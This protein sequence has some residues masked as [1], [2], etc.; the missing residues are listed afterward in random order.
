[1]SISARRWLTWG[2]PG[3][4]L[5]VALGLFLGWWLWP[6]GYAP[7][8][9]AY[10]RSDHRDEYVLMIAQAYQVD[11]DLAGARARLK[12]LDPADPIC[13]LQDLTQRLSASEG[14]ARQA[15]ALTSLADALEALEDSS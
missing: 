13:P 3:L 2:V 11:Q 10:L 7:T 8:S 14:G 1:M 4:V 15:E 5:G 6:L 9:P 12:T